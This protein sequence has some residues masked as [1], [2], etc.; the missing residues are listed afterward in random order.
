MSLC[1]SVLFFRQGEVLLGLL[2][3]HALSSSKVVSGGRAHGGRVDVSTIQRFLQQT[4]ESLHVVHD[5][6]AG[7]HASMCPPQWSS[8]RCLYTTL[9]RGR[10]VTVAR[11]VHTVTPSRL[12]ARPVSEAFTAL[13]RTVGRGVSGS[14]SGVRVAV[15]MHD[16]CANVC[17]STWR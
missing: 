5:F 8:G 1:C 7:K 2:P 15:C 6:G 13:N 3:H 12:S 9:L 10:H 14:E 17:A 4:A 16:A 11:G